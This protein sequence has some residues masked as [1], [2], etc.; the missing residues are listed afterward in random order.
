MDLAGNPIWRLANAAGLLSCLALWHY[1]QPT[2]PHNRWSADQLLSAEQLPTDNPIPPPSTWDWQRFSFYPLPELEATATEEPLTSSGVREMRSEKIPVFPHSSPLNLQTDVAYEPPRNEEIV[3]TS[4]VSSISDD[5]GSGSSAMGTTVYQLAAQ[6]QP[7]AHYK[8][9]SPAVDRRAYSIPAS[10][11][12]FSPD[13]IN[14]CYPYDPYMNQDV[15][16]GKTLNANQRPLLELG[17]PLYQLGPLSPG[18]SI[19]GFHN[20]VN[21]QF[22]IFGDFRQAISSNTVN[23]NN[24]SQMSFELNTIWSMYVTSTERLVTGVSPFD[25]GVNNTRWEFDRDVFNFDTDFD[26]D[27]GYLEGDLGAIAGGFTG[28]TLP[29]D[30]PFAVGLTPLFIQNGVWLNDAV[31]GMFFTSPAKNGPRLGISNMDL[32][33]AFIYDQINSAAFAGDNSAAKAYALF[34]FIEAWNGYVELDYAFVE[35]R[36][37]ADRSYH[38]IGLAY[39][40]RFGRFVSHS[41][42]V[43]AN[44]GQN[45]T[46]ARQTADGA[47]LL[48]ENSLITANPYTVIP[49]FNFFAGFDTPQGLAG[50]T[51]L[52]NTGILFESDGMSGYPTLDGR[53]NDTFGGAVGLNLL[54]ADFSQQLILEFASV[55]RQDDTDLAGD[56]YGI[57]T[58]YQLPLSNS[59]ILRTDS[60]YGFFR[61]DF[62]DFGM[63][64][65]LRKKF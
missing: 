51:E 64:V 15:Y 49:Y 48:L 11:E 29:F 27:F 43:I 17:R 13:P 21:P 33:L 58:R 44:A 59:W 10:I 19:L 30:L 25:D 41:T 61:N 5:A 65:E 26:F 7:G 3:L 6:P 4:S 34:T 1:C 60:M 42:R 12:D 28:K 35:D 24:R 20:N 46:G 18:S 2:Q 23:G 40:R 14:E 55:F 45:T 32:T 47:L 56:Q 54:A 39:S 9:E 16:Q 31:E 37:P 8:S 57:G 36:S 38:N 62:D 52:L 50:D 53:A 63:R 22:L